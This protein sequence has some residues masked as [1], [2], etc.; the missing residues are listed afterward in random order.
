[1]ADSLCR[2]I[3]KPKSVSVTYTGQSIYKMTC[4]QLW[5][6]YYMQGIGKFQKCLRLKNSGKTFR[7]SRN[8]QSCC[9]LKRINSYMIG[10]HY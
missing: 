5:Q 2:P 6:R 7:L 3:N 10:S 9:Y 8:G 4:K 1:M